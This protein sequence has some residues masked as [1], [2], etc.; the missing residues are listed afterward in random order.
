MSAYEIIWEFTVTRKNRA[1]FEAA[2]KSSGSW[3]EL[4]GKADGYIETKLL[5]DLE[6]DETYLTIDRWSSEEAFLK[7]RRDFAV[8]YQSLDRELEGLSERE[9]RVGVFARVGD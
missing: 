8:E 1:A 2:Y 4:F 7:F 3:A 9:R 5:R 6:R